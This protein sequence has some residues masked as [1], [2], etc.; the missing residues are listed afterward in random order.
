MHLKVAH[1]LK[2]GSQDI[3]VIHPRVPQTYLRDLQGKGSSQGTV[4]TTLS[5]LRLSD[6]KLG[7]SQNWGVWVEVSAGNQPKLSLPVDALHSPR[8][9]GSCLL[10][11]LDARGAMGAAVMGDRPPALNPSNSCDHFSYFKP[12]E[13]LDT[14]T[15]FGSPLYGYEPGA[16]I[17]SMRGWSEG[18]LRTMFHP[19]L[20]FCF[21]SWC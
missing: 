19:F 7:R 8:I 9:S 13:A 1:F 15:D 18:I 3:W 14:R 11:L 12:H 17:E 4:Q 2:V 20:F 16:G 10:A 21:S 6:H 5:Q